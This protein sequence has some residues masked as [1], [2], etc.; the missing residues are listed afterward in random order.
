MKLHRIA[1]TEGWQLI[2]ADD[3]VHAVEQV[4]N[5]DANDYLIADELDEPE[6]TLYFTKDELA[7]LTGA[8]GRT[9]REFP[10]FKAL[11]A[12]KVK[13][14]GAAWQIAAQQTLLDKAG[15]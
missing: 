4:I 15:E 8:V 6:A 3:P 9:A 7:Q 5:A 1:L 11:T 14:D 12:L 2:L 10:Q 13:L